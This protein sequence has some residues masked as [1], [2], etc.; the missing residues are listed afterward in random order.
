[1]R[2]S[3]AICTWNRED[4]LD[5][6]LTE[7]RQLQIPAG[8]DWELLVVNNNCSDQTDQVLARH[9]GRLPLRRLFEPRQGKSHAL[10]AAVAAVRGELIL[11]TDDDVLVDPQWLA[12]YATAARELPDAAFFGG[13]IQ[14]WFEAEPPAWLTEAWSQIADAYAFRDLGDQPFPIA[15][16]TLLNGANFAIR[17]DI[18]RAYPYDTRLGRVG[19]SEVRGEE[20][21]MLLSLIDDGHT[22]YWYPAARVR[23]FIPHARMTLDYI[24]RYYFGIGQTA[25]VTDAA[26]TAGGTHPW[27]R[28]RTW[29]RA[30]LSEAKYRI[31][32][33]TSRPA[34]WVD[35]LRKSSYRHGLLTR[36]ATPPPAQRKAA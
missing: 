8:I 6:T 14:P 17:T 11:W 25:A 26:A 22:G 15:Q 24:R 7:M 33:H 13:P 30:T 12:A 3:I 21:A 20:T 36:P 35:D 32:R 23:H 16:D 2:I 9:T 31:R 10:N 18:Q 27:R 29:L 1:M 5:R 34:V 19:A 28:A 4:L